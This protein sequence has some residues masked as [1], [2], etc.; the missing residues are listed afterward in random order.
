MDKRRIRSLFGLPI[1][2]LALLHPLA[3]HAAERP[4][5]NSV[6]M[7][8]VLIPAGSFLMGSPDDDK[9]ANRDEKPQHRVTISR[10]FHLGRYEVTQAQWEAVMS[11][12]PFT[13]PR[14]NSFYH[15]P[16]MAERLRKPDNPA[17]VSWNDA[18]EFITRL[19]QKEGHAR[20]RL[21][22]EAEWEYAARAGTTTPY[23]F[24]PDARNL[25]RYAW[26]D[27]DFE[28]GSTHAVGQKEPNAWGLYDMHGNVWEWTQDGYGERYYAESPAA[29]PTGPTT[30]SGN[31]G[32]VVR[33]GSWHVSGN[34]WRSA[35]R[36]HYAPDYRG[37]SVG[38]RLARTSE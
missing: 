18:Q 11:S 35:S 10:P 31:W 33:G 32:C 12:N 30:R 16:G 5:K 25:S 37:I 2:G 17:T 3:G 27:E 20:Y 19:N 26:F 15:L 4:L 23:S 38:F 6:G 8:F 14:S 22:T 28:T 29:D 21:P 9:D 34:G 7:E 36:R 1:M 13:L 24:G